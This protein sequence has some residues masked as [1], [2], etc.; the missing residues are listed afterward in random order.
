MA[1]SDPDS[2]LTNGLAPYKSTIII[3]FIISVL[4]PI[5]THLYLYRSV[6]AVTT[7]TFLVVGP[8]GAGKTALVTKVC[9]E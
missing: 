9:Y 4:L 7:P 8:S 2:W 1:W 6:A 5:L 3:A